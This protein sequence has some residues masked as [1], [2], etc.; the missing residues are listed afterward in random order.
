[1]ISNKKVEFEFRSSFNLK[2]LRTSDA[3]DS[4][5]VRKMSLLSGRM[6]RYYSGSAADL[7]AK[8]DCSAR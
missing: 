7:L 3:D 6:D 5:F 1:M 8:I 2:L 4:S